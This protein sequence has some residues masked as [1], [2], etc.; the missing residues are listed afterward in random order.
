VISVPKTNPFEDLD[1]DLKFWTPGICC[2]PRKK[3]F[4]CLDPDLSFGS[5]K[6]VARHSRFVCPK[7]GMEDEDEDEV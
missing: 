2:I 6:I 4:E 1:P 3:T 7:K 5:Q